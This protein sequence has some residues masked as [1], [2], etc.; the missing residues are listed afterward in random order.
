VPLPAALSEALGA[1]C[2]MNRFFD[3]LLGVERAFNRCR[4][5]RP[6][7]FAGRWLGPSGTGSVHVL[8]SVGD[9]FTIPE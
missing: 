3:K 4:H 5:R 7:R 6:P 2:A 8:N 1:G 9:D